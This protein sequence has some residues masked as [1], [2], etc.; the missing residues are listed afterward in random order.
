MQTFTIRDLRD[1]TG[2]LVRDAEAAVAADPITS[3]EAHPDRHA[4]I[5]TP[6]D[7]AALLM[8]DHG[9]PTHG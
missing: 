2:D 1:R 9:Y 3:V 8:N 7:I 4:K 6:K 5:P